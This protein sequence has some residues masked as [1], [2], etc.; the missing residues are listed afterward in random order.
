LFLRHFEAE[1]GV[2]PSG[3]PSEDVP[4]A[5]IF[6]HFWQKERVERSL[7]ARQ[8]REQRCGTDECP[9]RPA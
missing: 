6:E 3:G 5:L 7:G 1:L 4:T 9:M 2:F 8:E